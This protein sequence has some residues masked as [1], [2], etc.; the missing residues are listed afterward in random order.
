MDTDTVLP[1]IDISNPTAETGQKLYEAASTLGF[2]F[3]EGSEFT[4]D[5]INDMFALSKEFFSQPFDEKQKYA[6]SEAN[7]GYSCLNREVLDAT[8]K[9]GDPKEAFNFG[10]FKDDKAIQPL[11]PTFSRFE[12]DLAEFSKKCHATCHKLLDLLAVALK[13]DPAQGGAEWFSSRHDLKQVSGSILRFLYYPAVRNGD[14]ENEIRA[15]AH[16][17]Y[18]SMTLLFQRAGE[19]GL[20]VLSPI[21]NEWI[22]IPALQAKDSKSCPPIVV[23]IADQLSFWSANVLK[24]AVHR[25][26][27]PLHQVR[28]GLD[29]YSM[30]Y[31]C[32]PA[33]DTLLEPVPSPIIQSL[34]G[35]K[36]GDEVLTAGEHLTRRLAAAYS[37]KQ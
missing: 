36:N 35:A 32:H 33:D 12:Q 37:W 14:N 29:R 27:F 17:D 4:S 5:E 26:K 30:A 18:G 34:E 31:F 2:V 7:R 25:V 3:I 9:R 8:E 20:E 22:A 15:G 10:Q 1:V 28:S 21:T 19:E 13:I 24:S 16:T 23:N 6:I 11:P